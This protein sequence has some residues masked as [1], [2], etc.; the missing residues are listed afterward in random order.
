MKDLNRGLWLS[1]SNLVQAEGESLES[2]GISP[3]ITILG[4]TSLANVIGSVLV[5]L[6]G[7][8]TSQG[9]YY[10]VWQT[11]YISHFLMWT[12]VFLL[13]PLAWIGNSNGISWYISVAVFF[14]WAGVLLYPACLIY[15]GV[16]LF[17]LNN[18]GGYTGG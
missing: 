11:I 18:S 8:K 15:L 3:S 7:P 17:A 6:L 14:F 13:W 5:I 1:K 2:T 16:V 12:P 9:N 4:F 10:Y